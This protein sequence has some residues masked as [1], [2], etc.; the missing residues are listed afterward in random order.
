M[1]EPGGVPQNETTESSVPP[2]MEPRVRQMELRRDPGEVSKAREFFSE[3]ATSAALSPDRTE[4]GRL[5]V[6]ELVTNAI[7]H[8]A[9][10]MDVTT[11]V[12]PDALRVLVKD[13]SP[14]DPELSESASA[15]ST[16]GRGL[17]IVA[18]LT[19]RW[20]WE[21]AEQGDGKTVWFEL[22]RND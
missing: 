13:A 15:G 1:E 12:E 5:A 20:G 6:S 8:G 19:D 11:I 17:M 7:V 9:E 21:R 16:G 22:R 18:N 4:V 3:V 2:M 14:A 10:P